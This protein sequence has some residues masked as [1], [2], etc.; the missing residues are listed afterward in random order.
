MAPQIRNLFVNKTQLI[1]PHMKRVTLKGPDLSDFPSGYEGGYVRALFPKDTGDDN[2]QE[3]IKDRFLMRSYTVRNFRNAAQELDLDFVLHGD[4]GPAS[5]WAETAK[6]G[7]HLSIAG[8]GPVK[9]PPPQS[10]WVLFAGDMTSLPAIAVNLE[11]LSRETEGKAIILIESDED[12]VDL[13]EPPKVEV[14]WITDSDAKRGTETLISEF[15]KTNLMGSEP[16]VWAAGE[17]E[18]M[19]SARKYVKRL[20]TL[21]KDSSYVS[22]YWKSGETDEGMKKAKAALLATDG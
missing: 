6:E 10:D 12:R 20:D 13:R 9:R 3:A 15:E 16:F 19:R 4:S 5:K 14:Q 7:D 21:S 22:S 2:E 17:F 11:N 18:L 8:P 1:T